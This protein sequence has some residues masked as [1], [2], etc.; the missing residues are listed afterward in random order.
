MRTYVYIDGFNLY[1]RAL[2]N[3]FFKW[4]DL[5]SLLQ[6][7]L[8]SNNQLFSIKYFT[9][10]VSAPPKDP[11]K[12]TR[13]MT[14]IRALQEHIPEIEVYYGSFL[15]H[16]VWAGLANPTKNNKKVQVKKTEEKGSDVNLAV[17]LLNDAWQ[18]LY[19]CGVIVS[20]D[21]D[22]VEPIRL[23]KKHHNKSIGVIFPFEKQRGSKQ[24][25]QE[26]SFVRKI[27][28]GALKQSQLPD[29]I[30]DTNIYKPSRW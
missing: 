25:I 22:L 4:L 29:P 8:H 20:N 26:A 27:R 7:I 10:K 2:K 13:Q 3:T 15:T 17:H 18:D 28:L 19:D 24:L 16:T 9:A 5:K 23:V 30:P 11:N 1:H 14:Y 6:K 12:P 21:S